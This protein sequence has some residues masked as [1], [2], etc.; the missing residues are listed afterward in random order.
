MS[1]LCANIFLIL[2]SE[3]CH[4]LNAWMKSLIIQIDELK[5]QSDQKV[6]YQCKLFFYKGKG[7][8]L[9]RLTNIPHII[10]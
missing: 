8:K 4:Q 5:E 1:K 3:P 9:I 6:I 7:I 2:F 10:Y